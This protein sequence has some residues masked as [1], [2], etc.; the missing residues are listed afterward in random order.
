MIRETYRGVTLQTAK[1]KLGRTKLTVN[2]VN[3]GDQDGIE[4]YVLRIAKG[5]VDLV[6]DGD[7]YGEHEA[8]WYPR[9]TVS[10]E[11]LTRD[12]IA[13][14]FWTPGGQRAIVR[15][16]VAQ[17]ITEII[18]GMVRTPANYDAAR[19]LLT[20]AG[21]ETVRQIIGNDAKAGYAWREIG[22]MIEDAEREVV[23]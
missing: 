12:I 15:E 4:A 1:G 21:A 9:G 17:R 20:E 5:T 16:Y 3:L 14:H 8:H 2:G 22:Q 18:E 13:A 11:T 7:G 10:P 19:K 23:K 6:Q